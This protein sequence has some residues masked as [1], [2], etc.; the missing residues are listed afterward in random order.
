[1]FNFKSF[2]KNINKKTKKHKKLK[3]KSSKRIKTKKLIFKDKLS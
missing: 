3:D 1:M 2:E